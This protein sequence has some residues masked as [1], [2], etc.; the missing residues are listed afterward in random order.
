M[1]G[2]GVTVTTRDKRALIILGVTLVLF[3]LLQG[4]LFFP[5][6]FSSESVNSESLEGIE[7]QFRLTRARAGRI[8]LVQA[9][10]KTVQENLERM[11]KGLLASQNIALAQAEMRQILERSLQAED[12]VMENARFVSAES[13]N[14][15]YA[16][17][18]VTVNFSCHIEQLVNWVAAVGNSSQLLSTI[19]IRIDSPNSDSKTVRV[20]ATVAGFLPASRAPELNRAQL[21]AGG[22]L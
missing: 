14:D 19:K 1:D 9:Q 10:A 15:H 22:S 7:R 17:I 18:P 11:E 4:D 16:A 8:P 6:G 21:S 3:M 12:I 13:K 5:T 2:L 20:T